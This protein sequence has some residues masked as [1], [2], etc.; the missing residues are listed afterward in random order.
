MTSNSKF[1]KDREEEITEPFKGDLW[2]RKQ[3][4]E[5]LTHFISNLQCGATIAL[6]AEW[7]AGKTWFVKNWKADLEEN[8]YK[9][10]YL[11]AFAHD[12]M[13]DPFLI[14]SMEI[15][16]IVDVNASVSNKFKEKFISAYHAVLPNLPMLIWSLAMT[17]M[18]GGHFSKGIQDTITAVKEGTGDVGEKAG[19][20][21]EEGLKEHLTEL[22]D[23]YNAY[24]NGIF[25]SPISG[26]YMI[27]LSFQTTSTNTS[28][29]SA[30]NVIGVWN[31]TTNKWVAR[32]NDTDMSI[33][34]TNKIRT[35][36][37]L[38]A[39]NMTAGTNYSIRFIAGASGSTTNTFTVLG[40]TSLVNTQN[41]PS[42]I[43]IIR[44][45]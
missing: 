23:N 36:K 28:N 22:V 32:I 38:T 41:S 24:S 35:S 9:V 39:I 34:T 2:E 6:D 5:K 40:N 20:L 3:L 19:E 31:D 30:N 45:K 7:G 44:V 15:L 1:I 16:N 27:V 18:G 17:L 12:F 33:N 26:V 43:R 10:I 21:L 13:E 29:Y 4:S 37:L 14:L 8:E 42:I 11:D 25:T